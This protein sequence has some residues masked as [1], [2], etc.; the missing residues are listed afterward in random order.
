MGLAAKARELLASTKYGLTADGSVVDMGP[1]AMAR[2]KA[3]DIVFKAA[4][5]YPDRSEAPSVNVQVIV[6][7]PEDEISPDPFAAAID[8]TTEQ[9]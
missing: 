8:V 1:D 3:L 4:G 7:R 5:A 2:V 6:L 9:A